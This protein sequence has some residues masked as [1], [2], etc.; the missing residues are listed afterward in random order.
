MATVQRVK[1]CR[2]HVRGEFVS[3]LYCRDCSHRFDT[4]Q[5]GSLDAYDDDPDRFCPRCKS[6]YIVPQIMPSLHVVLFA[7]AIMVATLICAWLG[8]VWWLGL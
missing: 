8:R 1:P 2:A 6:D 4:V 7:T 5:Y 3:R